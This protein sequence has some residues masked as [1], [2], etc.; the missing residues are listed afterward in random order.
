MSHSDHR[1]NINTSSGSK[2]TRWRHRKR[3][4]EF[5]VAQ[6]DGRRKKIFSEQWDLSSAPACTSVASK[7]KWPPPSLSSVEGVGLQVTHR[8]TVWKQRGILD[9]ND[10]KERTNFPI[11]SFC[12]VSCKI[13]TCL[14]IFRHLKSSQDFAHQSF[15]AW[16]TQ[17][18]AAS[19]RS[20]SSASQCCRGR[21]AGRVSPGNVTVAKPPMQESQHRHRKAHSWRHVRWRRGRPPVWGGQRRSGEWRQYEIWCEGWVPCVDE[22]RQTFRLSWARFNLHDKSGTLSQRL[23]ERVLQDHLSQ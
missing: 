10:G 9:T 1:H 12:N 18:G 17:S 13:L 15:T 5:D 6:R 11:F 21:T 16:Q 7:C 22:L 23:M 20:R 2:K 19:L 14:R 8:H 3:T 4:S